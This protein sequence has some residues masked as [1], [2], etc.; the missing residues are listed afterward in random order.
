MIYYDEWGDMIELKQCP[1]CFQELS[2]KN[3]KEYCNNCGFSF[4]CSDL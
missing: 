4:D 1:R 2:K 3:C